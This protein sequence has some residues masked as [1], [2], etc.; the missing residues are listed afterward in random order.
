MMSVTAGSAAG[1][2]PVSF[3]VMIASVSPAGIETLPADT[4]KT[5]VRTS[6]AAS[7]GGDVSS[8][9]ICTATSFLCLF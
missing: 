4:A 9:R 6:K 1:T 8:D 2:L 7:A 3:A 5:A